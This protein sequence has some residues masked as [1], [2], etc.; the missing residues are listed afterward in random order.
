VSA[1]K[2]G[3]FII[4]KATSPS[5]KHYVGYTHFSLKDRMLMHFSEARK[6]I[7]RP[8]YN[9]LRKYGN[10][11]KWEIIATYQTESFAKNRERY[12]IKLTKANVPKIGYNCT[13][14][15][16]GTPGL[17][18]KSQMKKIIDANGIIYESLK[19]VC[20]TFNIDKGE[21]NTALKR[22]YW[23]KNNYFSY[24][25]EGMTAA[26]K[27]KTSHKRR[28]K[29]IN[30]TTG[31]IFDSIK[32]AAEK[33]KVAPQRL[34]QVCIGIRSKTRGQVFKYLEDK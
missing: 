13:S 23:C 19:S 8:F 5:G 28:R 15:G 16:E 32:E 26:I 22:N 3:F 34:Y 6:G 21:L 11:V 12:F 27:P 14:G 33:Y 31:E 4:Y 2:T 29:V 1:K 30:I 10:K 9:C 17:V 7:R 24:Y 25:I 18:R 20:E